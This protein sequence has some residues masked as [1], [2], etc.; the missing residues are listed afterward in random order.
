MVLQ[1]YKMSVEIAELYATSSADAEGQQCTGVDAVR[2]LWTVQEHCDRG[3][4]IEAGEKAVNTS[5]RTILCRSAVLAVKTAVCGAD[6]T[7]W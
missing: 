1:T 4:L 6:H 3:M 5:T 2:L 7:L